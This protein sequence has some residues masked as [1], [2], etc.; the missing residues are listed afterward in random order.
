ME[1]ELLVRKYEEKEVVKIP[2]TCHV[3][4]QKED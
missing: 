4:C 1:K 3:S 2:L